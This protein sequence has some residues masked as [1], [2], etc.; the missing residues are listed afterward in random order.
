MLLD[1]G[2]GIGLWRGGGADLGGFVFGRGIFVMS[3]VV[4]V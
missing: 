3:Q 1:R 2:F 4:M